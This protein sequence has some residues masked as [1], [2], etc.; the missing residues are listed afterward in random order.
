MV[1]YLDELARAQCITKS[2]KMSL[3]MSGCKLTH[4]RRVQISES[5]R[6]LGSNSSIILRYQ[7][8]D[9]V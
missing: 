9:K 2:K 3:S 6:F 7:N 4:N 5:E 1:G 8:R